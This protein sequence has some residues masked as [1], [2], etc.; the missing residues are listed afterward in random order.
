MLDSIFI[1]KKKYFWPVIIFFFAFF[2]IFFVLM[3]CASVGLAARLRDDICWLVLWSAMLSFCLLARLRD[4]IMF[5]S[6]CYGLYGRVFVCWRGCAMLLVSFVLQCVAC[7]SFSAMIFLDILHGCLTVVRLSEDIV[8]HPSSLFN[9]SARTSLVRCYQLYGLQ[10]I[11]FMQ[12][13]FRALGNLDL[14]SHMG[15][16][17]GVPAICVPIT[18]ESS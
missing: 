14:L 12:Y 18:L 5:G 1:V 7:C 11:I 3:E 17:R 13:R 2:R 15:F 8:K 16:E 10:R 9:W 6:Y 4:D